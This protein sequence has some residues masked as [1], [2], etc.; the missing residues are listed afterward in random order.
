MNLRKFLKIYRKGLIMAEKS[1][2]SKKK[3]EQNVFILTHSDGPEE[4]MR[5]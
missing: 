2:D 3:T 4:E 1:F 5:I